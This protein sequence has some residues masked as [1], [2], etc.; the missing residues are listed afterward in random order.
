MILNTVLIRDHW[1]KNVITLNWTLN[2]TASCLLINENDRKFQL[3][4][5]FNKVLAVYLS[6]SYMI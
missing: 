1:D 5:W 6:N 3:W 2:A 4:Q